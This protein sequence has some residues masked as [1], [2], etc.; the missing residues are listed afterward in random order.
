[1]RLVSAQLFSCEK[2]H[3]HDP[4]YVVR[5]RTLLY[6]TTSHP[7]VYIFIQTLC[8]LNIALNF[9]L[10]HRLS[11]WRCQYQDCL[12]TGYQTR[13]GSVQGP[14]GVTSWS[15]EHWEDLPCGFFPW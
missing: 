5:T 6:D 4:Y 13:T 2:A 7:L 1:M 9:Y 11:D 10:L 15:R 8:A 12:L 14:T 3:L